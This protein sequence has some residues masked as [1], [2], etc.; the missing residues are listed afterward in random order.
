MT[1]AWRSYAAEVLGTF[2]LVFVGTTAVVAA[3]RAD[4]PALVAAPFAFGLALLAGLYA[5][6]EVS[7]GHFNP[8]VSLAL[9]L[10]GRLPRSDLIPYWIAQFVGGILASLVLLVAS[11]QDDVASTATKPFAGDGAAFVIEVTL[12]AIFVL[13]ILQSTRSE[14]F[15]GSALVAI[16][17]A[18]LAAH[19]AAIPFSGCSLNPARTFG[20]DLVGNTWTGI[21]IYFIATPL[22]AAIA[23]VI[24]SAV[25]TG[26]LGAPTP[27][28]AG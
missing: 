26:K 9:F 17:L 28:K 18:L 3:G 23:W 19:F 1:T 6:G 13:V 8:V 27:S 22:G 2:T 15:G 24:H 7:G 16:P 11:D 4:T 10:D 25:V 12:T 5:F 21:W 14:R 20:P